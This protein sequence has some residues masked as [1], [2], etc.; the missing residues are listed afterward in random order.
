MI[1]LLALLTS[2][3]ADPTA[4]RAPQAL[5]FSNLFDTPRYS[6]GGWAKPQI[7]WAVTY[8]YASN[9]IDLAVGTRGTLAPLGD[10]W[11]LEAQVSGGPLVPLLDPDIGLALSPSLS[12]E[13]HNKI[14]SMSY[15]VAV[16]FAATFLNTPQVRIPVQGEAQFIWE[17]GNKEVRQFLGFVG[18]LGASFNLGLD[19]S[20]T[21]EGGFIWAFGASRVNASVEGSEETIS[22]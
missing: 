6:F 9:A 13:Y 19:T 14:F 18:R 16:P 7:G 4:L 15:G 21:I 22:P 2:A 8:T 11:T 20:I 17:V 1:W 5:E 3:H 12:F 10:K